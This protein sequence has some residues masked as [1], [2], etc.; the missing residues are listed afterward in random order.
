MPL[1]ISPH[2]PISPWAGPPP[3]PTR[4][5]SIPC[6]GGGTRPAPLAAAAQPSRRRGAREPDARC[7]RPPARR[8]PHRPPALFLGLGLAPRLAKG[9]ARAAGEP[10]PSN[11]RRRPTPRIVRVRRRGRR[12][13]AQEAGRPATQQDAHP[14]PTTERAASLGGLGCERDR[15][16]FVWLVRTR[17]RTTHIRRARRPDSR[18]PPPRRRAEALPLAPSRGRAS[19]G[20]PPAGRQRGRHL[21]PGTSTAPRPKAPPPERPHVPRR[22]TSARV[23]QSPG[24]PS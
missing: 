2:P 3:A 20:R 11:A 6:P 15:G 4:R 21:D 17:A 5:P 9:R 1:P 8:N 7:R 24:F 10:D 18:P 13:P 16:P 12:T 22:P 23:Q 19:M 14:S